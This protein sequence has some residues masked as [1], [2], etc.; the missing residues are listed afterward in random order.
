MD[1]NDKLQAFGERVSRVKDSA[2][3]EE[4][5]KMYLI[6]PFLRLLGYDDTNPDDI[7]PEY[8]AGFG[9][10]QAPKVDYAVMDGTGQPIIIIEAKCQ[11]TALNDSHASQLAQ[12]FAATPVRLGILTNGLVWRCY[13]DLQTANIM[14]NAPFFV[15]NVSEL[16]TAP[17]AVIAKI[18]KGQFDLSGMTGIAQELEY[19]KRVKTFLSK[20]F[21]GQDD[22]FVKLVLAGVEYQGNR[23]SNAV[24]TFRPIIKRVFASLLDERF[25][26]DTV[27]LEGN[28]NQADGNT[29][30]T[31]MEDTWLEAVKVALGDALTGHTLQGEKHTRANPLPSY[32][33][34]MLDGLRHK[35]ICRLYIYERK[36]KLFIR[37]HHPDEI[38]HYIDTPADVQSHSG[39]LVRQLRNILTPI[40]S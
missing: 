10:N 23:T 3:T 29:L 30:S 20:C 18:R 4:A 37:K 7:K 8:N 11:S 14:D 28:N 27:S 26:N 32:L 9:V 13:T 22:N 39:D 31:N 19:T 21:L 6:V 24:A 40:T 5:T 38:K 36:K 1:F 15:F 17:M 12:Y 25:Q 34:V 33:S 35:I 2:T 16:T